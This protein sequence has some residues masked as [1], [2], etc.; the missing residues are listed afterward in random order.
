M[1]EAIFSRRCVEVLSAS[2]AEEALG[3]LQG[4]L[5]IDAFLCDLRRGGMA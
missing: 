5:A 3:I 4:P 1:T 2:T